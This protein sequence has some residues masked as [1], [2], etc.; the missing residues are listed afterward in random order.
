MAM[1]R[2]STNNTSKLFL[3]I[4]PPLTHQLGNFEDYISI[5][6]QKQTDWRIVRAHY[7]WSKGWQK[8]DKSA[9]F[10]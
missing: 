1:A 9:D 10:T 5:P 6:G 3:R 2:R 7:K 4:F 8:A